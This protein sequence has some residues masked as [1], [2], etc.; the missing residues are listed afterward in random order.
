MIGGKY[1]FAIIVGGLLVLYVFNSKTKQF[2][3]KTHHGLKTKIKD[4]T[5]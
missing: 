4:W 1:T 3:K 5:R 2:V